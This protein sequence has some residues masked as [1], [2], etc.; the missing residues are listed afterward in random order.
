MGRETTAIVHWMGKA[1]EAKILLESQEFI[2][3]GEHKLKLP[4]KS[5]S[6]CS[7]SDGF[8]C[9]DIEGELLK[10]K[11]PENEGLRWLAAIEKSPPT[12][13][14]KLG[15]SSDNAAFVS[16]NTTDSELLNALA[17]RTVDSL[18]E[19]VY[20]VAI[21]NS[22]KDLH[23]ALKL[24]KEHK[25]LKIWCVY[26]KGMNNHLSDGAIRTA[27]RESGFIDS[28]SSGVSTTLTATR[29]NYKKQ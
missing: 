19:A 4:R 28:K 23:A 15:I 22:K 5:I 11:L 27:M 13:A 21:L 10:I 2:L 24:G 26:K 20:L 25:H 12:L 17:G 3:R 1:A 29:Y 6:K 7:Y 9:L 14:E 18:Q 16:G 8:L